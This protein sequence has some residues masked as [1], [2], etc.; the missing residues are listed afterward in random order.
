MLCT[1]DSHHAVRWYGD[2]VERPPVRREQSLYVYWCWRL[3][4]ALEGC[5]TPGST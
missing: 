2:S 1:S 5:Y 4:R 3:E